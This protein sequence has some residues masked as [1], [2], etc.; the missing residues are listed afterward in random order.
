MPAKIST[1]NL[2]DHDDISDS[3]IGRIISWITT[4]GRY[5]MITTEIIVLLA[6]ISR[7][8]L[9]RKLTDLNEEIDQK[10]AILDINKPFEDNFRSIQ[11]QLIQLKTI[12]QSQNHPV[13]VIKSLRLLL[14]PGTYITTL[15]LTSGTINVT[16]ISNTI[17]SFSQFI[18]NLQSTTIITNIEVGSIKRDIQTGLQYN[19]SGQYMQLRLSPAAKEKPV[20]N[21]DL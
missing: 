12:I 4:N 2:L 9:D 19:F 16:A 5:I 14:P 3:P 1:V 15:N 17:E 6:F 20:E 13:D 10:K 11:N 7:F 21:E 8:S 18:N